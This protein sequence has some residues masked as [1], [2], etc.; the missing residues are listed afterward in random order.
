MRFLDRETD[1]HAREIAGFYAPDDLERRI[2]ARQ[3]FGGEQSLGDLIA[4]LNSA[5]FGSGT[6][7]SQSEGG[8]TG[9]RRHRAHAPRSFGAALIASAITC[10]V[11]AIRIPR[12]T[13]SSPAS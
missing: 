13:P 5:V 9:R 12:R 6:G 7:A 8:P 11:A 10:L 2:A 3:V 4:G 1:A